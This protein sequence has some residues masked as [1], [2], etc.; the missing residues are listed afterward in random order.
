M[1]RESCLFCRIVDRKIASKIVREDDNLIAFEDIKPQA[2]VHVLIVPKKHIDR[3]SDLSGADSKLIADAMLMAVN[4]A[5][6][7]DIS[8]SGYRIVINCDKDAGQ[9]V[10]HMHFH[11]LGGRLFSWPPG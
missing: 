8:D 9:E 4:I 6:E 7:R 11:L 3:V 10:F 5:R 1:I 2:P